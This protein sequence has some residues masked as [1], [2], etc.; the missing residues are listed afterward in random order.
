MRITHIFFDIGGVL[1]T[2]GWDA[3][4]R[5]LGAERFELDYADFTRRHQDADGMLEAGRMALDEY[6]DVT[7]FHR[8]RTFTREAFK[9]YMWEQSKPFPET[10]AIAR[11][12]AGGGTGS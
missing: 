1:G 5:A 11:A 2:D 4:Q 10:I 8:P 6:L 12:L 9:Q 7:V 3:Q